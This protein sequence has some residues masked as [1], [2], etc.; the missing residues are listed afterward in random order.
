MSET[1]DSVAAF[2]EAACA[3]LDAGHALG[4]LDEAQ[5]I[6]GSHPGLAGQSIY[7]AAILGDDIAVRGWLEKDPGLATS[8]GGPRGW[9][10]LTHLCFS[11]YLR[12]DPERS[13]AFVRAATALLDAGAPPNSGWYEKN[14]R[15]EPEWESVLYGAAGIAHHEGL[16]RLLLARGADP[17]DGETPY[18]APESHEMGVLRALVESGRLNDE[19]LAT[20]LLRKTDWHHDEAIRWLLEQGVDPNLMTHWGKTAL[21]NALVSDNSIAIIDALLEHGANPAL[22]GDSGHGRRGPNLS[23]ISIAAR[24]G[25]DDVLDLL[26]RRG[27]PLGLDG[28]ERLIAACARGDAD[29]IRSITSEER[30][31]VS[32][33]LTEGGTLLAEFA[34]NGNTNGVRSLLDL[35]VEVDALYARGDVYFGIAA[36]STALHVASWKA[37]HDTVR[38]LIDRGAAIDAVDGMGRTPLLLAVKACVDSYWTYRRAV[39]SVEALLSAGASVRGVPYPSGFSEVDALLESHGASRT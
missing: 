37:R 9:D 24:R 12:L 23:S 8:K 11:R 30:G 32:E 3:P 22:R 14:H 17:N 35:G 6:L 33:L 15:P 21:H 2:I 26:E 18:H 31:L 20:I 38:L 39:D 36:N 4:T 5:A 13:D 25:R 27:I 1:Y 19:S 7:A 28:A 10:A 34:G 29:G 16:T